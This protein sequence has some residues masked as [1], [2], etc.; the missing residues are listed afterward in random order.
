MDKSGVSLRVNDSVSRSSLQ[1]EPNSKHFQFSINRLK[2]FCQYI[3]GGDI[4]STSK[5]AAKLLPGDETVKIVEIDF[6]PAIHVLRGIGE[7]FPNLNELDILGESIKFVKREDFANMT[8]L[9]V[10]TMHDLLIDFLPKDLLVD[11]TNLNQIAITFCA[12]EEVPEVFFVNQEK[13]EK[14]SLR[15]N[16]LKD[17]HAR[18]F[19]SNPMLSVVDL[20]GNNL[21][22]INVDFT[23]LPALRFIILYNNACLNRAYVREYTKSIKS[24]QHDIEIYCRN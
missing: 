14:L 4:N 1:K 21:Q 15:S 10:L 9:S 8:Q 6:Y 2:H 3:A 19:K 16:R 20:E 12:I 7:E 18:L 17:L 24:F 5:F 22:K 13:L 11:L 23:R